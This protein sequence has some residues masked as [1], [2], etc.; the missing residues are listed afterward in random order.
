MQTELTKTIEIPKLFYSTWGEGFY[1]KVWINQ[2]NCWMYS[3]L[4][5]IEE[6][7][8]FKNDKEAL[9]FFE[10]MAAS[11]YEFMYRNPDQSLYA[12]D[13]FMHYLNEI[14]KR[15]EISKKEVISAFPV[16][17]FWTYF[18]YAVMLDEEP[19]PGQLEDV[20]FVVHKLGHELDDN[21]EDKKY[22][23]FTSFKINHKNFVVYSQNFILYPNLYY[24]FSIHG[25][26]LSTTFKTPERGIPFVIAN[27]LMSVYVYDYEKL[28]KK[29]FQAWGFADELPA[30]Y[31]E[32]KGSKNNIYSRKQ[33]LEIL[34][35]NPRTAIF[36]YNK[37]CYS[38]I[39]FRDLSPLNPIVVFDDKLS[40]ED[41]ADYINIPK[42]S[43]LVTNNLNDVNKYDFNTLV[44]TCNINFESELPLVEKLIF[45]AFEKNMPVILLYD[46]IFK[47][48]T[49][50]KYLTDEIASRLYR[51]SLTQSDMDKIEL[52]GHKYEVP[53]KVIGV[54]GTDSVQGKFTT[55]ILLREKLK[56]LNKIIHYAT[57]PTGILVGADISFSRYE[58]YTPEKAMTYQQKLIA[59]LELESD[60]ILTGGQNSIIF[61]QMRDGDLTKNVSTRI[62]RTL[63]PD[64]IILTT[65]VD[66]ELKIILDALAYI[67]K[68]N[69]LYAYN[70]EVVAFTMLVGRKIHGERWT[71]TY[72]IDID[73]KIIES[74]KRKVEDAAGI[75]VYVVPEEAGDLAKAISL[76][77]V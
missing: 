39:R 27:K 75:K 50:Q 69:A 19:D 24:R 7:L 42:A 23:T 66:T 36:K 18:S 12:A 55:Q 21:L 60:A 52:N 1:S 47:L 30:R 72:F 74:A 48:E 34:P 33:L 11:D 28:S 17:P 68:L 29:L 40:L 51:I 70:A 14:I 45:K 5:F 9:P 56:K 4:K 46:D 44:F 16:D 54:F 10:K 3:M 15:I 58:E 49:L 25:K 26:N 13:E 62:F 38:L 2:E 6:N 20:D 22:N 53:Q 64:Y 8:D 65:S 67:E 31:E 61:D 41:A 59:S 57:E 73:D 76:C 35:D 63:K 32:N 37:E 77:L 71:E 43:I